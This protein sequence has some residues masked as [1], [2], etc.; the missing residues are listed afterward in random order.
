MKTVTTCNYQHKIKGN[1]R[2][3]IKQSIRP[4]LCNTQYLLER[5]PGKHHKY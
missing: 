2:K 5:N 1:M 4:A 3:K